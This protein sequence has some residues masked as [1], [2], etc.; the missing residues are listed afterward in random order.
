MHKKKYVCFEHKVTMYNNYVENTR[1]HCSKRPVR[2]TARICSPLHCSCLIQSEYSQELLG[3]SWIWKPHVCTLV[4][5]LIL[6][7]D[8]T[9]WTLTLK[10]KDW[11]FLWA[12]INSS[13]LLLPY[14]VTDF[15]LIT[16]L[17]WYA[18][19][20]YAR[21]TNMCPF[22]NVRTSFCWY[23]PLPLASP[24]SFLVSQLPSVSES[25]GMCSTSR[26]YWAVRPEA[27]AW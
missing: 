13:V 21:W 11:T 1:R 7:A 17:P 26:H 6:T 15:L 5:R 23:E 3:R 27:V 20:H 19:F 10:V 4:S 14:L 25:S 8:S 24:S 22:L 9:P 16:V 18:S 12:F 2:S